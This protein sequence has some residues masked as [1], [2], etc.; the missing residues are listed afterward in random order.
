M[1][2]GLLADVHGNLHALDRVLDLLAT[3]RVDAYVCAGDLVGYGPFPNECI[4]R[5]TAL[6]ATCVAGNHDLIATARLDPEGIGTLARRSLG[7]TARE[8]R[9]ETAE[10]LRSLPLTARIGPVLIAHGSLDDPSVYVTRERADGELERLERVRPAAGVLVL[11]HT[12]RPGA[13]G[14]ES[15]ELLS[16]RSGTVSFKRSEAL[17]LNPGSVGQSR[18]RRPV[19]R[20]AVLDLAEREVDLR[21]A[22]YDHHAC[23]RALRARGLPP[24]SYHRN[25]DGAR[26]R[27][28]RLRRRARRLA[29]PSS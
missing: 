20:F 16:H 17:V 8:L 5:V 9:P 15:G 19:A 22:A 27:L 11:G 23:R 26:A 4:E 12:H 25:P 1:R 6:G 7:W 18:E 29:Q 28:G 10:L 14:S 24:R 21:D 3:E 2:L 13:F